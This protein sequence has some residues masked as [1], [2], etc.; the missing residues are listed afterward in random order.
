MKTCFSPLCRG[1]IPAYAGSTSRP[2]RPA[3][4]SPDHPR[5]RGEHTPPNNR[6]PQPAGSSPHT[7]GALSEA[8][9][10]MYSNR[11]IPAYAGST[12]LTDLTS[13]GGGDH[14]RIRGE[15]PC[16]STRPSRAS[17]IIPA[18]AGSTRPELLGAQG[19]EDHPRIRGEHG[20]RVLLRT[21]GEGSSPHTRGARRHH[22][23]HGDWTGII[24]AYAGSTSARCARPC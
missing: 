7:R 15:H 14:P 19:V 20:D 24:P 6:G 16:T 2:P 8:L 10:N 18:Y 1:I 9:A 5:I 12:P 13:V 4:S 3:P 22:L 21:L 23:A 11:I 17:R